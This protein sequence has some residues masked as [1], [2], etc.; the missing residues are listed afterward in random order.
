MPTASTTKGG[1]VTKQG[2]KVGNTT[3]RGKSKM[4]RGKSYDE[5]MESSSTLPTSTSATTDET[6]KTERTTDMDVTAESKQTPQPPPAAKTTK[7]IKKSA[8][9]PCGSGLKYRKCCQAEQKNGSKKAQKT[10]NRGRTEEEEDKQE[11]TNCIPTE[12]TMKG[13]FRVLEI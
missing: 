10:N 4:S 8:P 2:K 5:L 7:V 11:T 3:P 13:K 1:T 6:S 9:C 12:T